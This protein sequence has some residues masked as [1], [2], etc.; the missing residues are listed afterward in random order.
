MSKETELVIETVSD[1]LVDEFDALM[2]EYTLDPLMDPEEFVK[3]AYAYKYKLTTGLS[4]IKKVV[5]ATG[6]EG[7]QKLPQNV[8]TRVMYDWKARR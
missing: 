1:D 3:R 7:E 6:K 8:V 4:I 5:E 2:R